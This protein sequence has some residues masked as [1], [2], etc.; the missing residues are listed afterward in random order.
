[1]PLFTIFLY[2]AL[3]FFPSFGVVVFAVAILPFVGNQSK[4]N[5]TDE[6]D[7]IKR[8]QNYSEAAVEQKKTPKLYI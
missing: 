1:M 2:F 7:E 4:M 5:I 6:I 3:I 8:L